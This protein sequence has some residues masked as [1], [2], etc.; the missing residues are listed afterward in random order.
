MDISRSNEA[1]FPIT[2]MIVTVP[3]PIEIN[4]LN[5][6][7]FFLNLCDCFRGYTDL[8]RV[9]FRDFLLPENGS[10]NSIFN[11]VSKINFNQPTF[12]NST[13]ILFTSILSPCLPSNR[14]I[15]F[16]GATFT[17]IKL[18]IA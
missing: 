15:L 3:I 7:I 13:K 5:I 8:I 9:I 14:P 16:L 11:G 10:K 2:Q 4:V 17:T 1:D 12:L 6:C 18:I